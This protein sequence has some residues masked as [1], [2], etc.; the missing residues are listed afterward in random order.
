MVSDMFAWEAIGK[1]KK[2]EVDDA[3]GGKF[4]ATL[5]STRTVTWSWAVENTYADDR[6]SVPLGEKARTYHSSQD[7]AQL[8]PA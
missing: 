7:H 6:K 3:H 5:A 2:T 1:L 4:H 8:R